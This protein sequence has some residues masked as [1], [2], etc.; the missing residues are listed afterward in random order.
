VTI[1]PNVVIYPQAKIGDRTTLH[2]NCTIHERTR[3][4]AD[5]VIHSGAVISAEGFG[6]VLTRTG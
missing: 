3:I 6:F 2:A 4:G 1:H 5:C